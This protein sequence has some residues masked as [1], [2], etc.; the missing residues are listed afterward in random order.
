MMMMMTTTLKERNFHIWII[1]SICFGRNKFVQI[2]QHNSVGRATANGMHIHC[3][4]HRHCIEK[5]KSQHFVSYHAFILHCPCPCATLSLTH[6]FNVFIKIVTPFSNKLLT[7]SIHIPLSI[8]WMCECVRLWCGS[9]S[10]YVAQI[11]T[12]PWRMNEQ[13]LCKFRASVLR[14]VRWV[15]SH[16]P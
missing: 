8:F 15:R 4:R 3:H 10:C 14:Y 11:P 2:V 13:K 7:R 16:L 5:Q 6:T 1:V 12:S 9:C